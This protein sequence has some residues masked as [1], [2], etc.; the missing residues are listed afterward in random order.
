M[1]LAT[2]IHDVLVAVQQ[3]LGEVVPGCETVPFGSTGDGTFVVRSRT[4]PKSPKTPA[5]QPDNGF[6]RLGAQLAKATKRSAFSAWLV[7]GQNYDRLTALIEEHGVRW[8]VIATWAVVEGHTKG[9]PLTPI[10]AKRTY[11]RETARR[12]KAAQKAG[13]KPRSQPVTIGAP[14]LA[15]DPQ[16]P[17]LPPITD[18]PPASPRKR[19]ELKPVTIKKQP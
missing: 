18:I 9:N 13:A 2:V 19:L 4:M 8:D 3:Y 12:Q 5:D 10:A 1:G 15:A 14:V 16:P 17:P 6:N 11:E 7:Q